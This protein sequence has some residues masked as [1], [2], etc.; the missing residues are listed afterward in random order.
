MKISMIV[1]FG[2]I[3]CVSVRAYA[4]MDWKEGAL[5]DEQL[6]ADE[7]E[8]RAF[9]Q[10]QQAQEEIDRLKDELRRQQMWS[11]QLNADRQQMR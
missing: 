7:A 3:L 6:R 5:Y 8:E 4:Q 1:L 11:D 2:I 9:L 10:A